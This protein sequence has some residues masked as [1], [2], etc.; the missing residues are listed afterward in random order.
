VT[1]SPRTWEA[2]PQQRKDDSL[3]QMQPISDACASWPLQDGATGV[4]IWDESNSGTTFRI[5]PIDI[6]DITPDYYLQFI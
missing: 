2:S 1:A 5:V 6:Y 4:R 3:M